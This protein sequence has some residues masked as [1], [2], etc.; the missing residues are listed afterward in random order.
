M[1]MQTVPTASIC[2]VN[3]SSPRGMPRPRVAG[4]SCNVGMLHRLHRGVFAVMTVA[5]HVV[6]GGRGADR[7]VLQAVK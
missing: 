3:T 2:L 6:L 7:N 4:C 1:G 5:D